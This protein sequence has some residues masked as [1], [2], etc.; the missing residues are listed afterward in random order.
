M[1]SLNKILHALIFMQTLGHLGRILVDLGK[2]TQVF[3]ANLH[4]SKPIQT[5]SRLSKS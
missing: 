2:L 4:F 5:I 3:R 1:Q